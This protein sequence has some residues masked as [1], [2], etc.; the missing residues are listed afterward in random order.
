MKTNITPNKINIAVSAV[1]MGKL[2][3]FADAKITLLV[4]N[5]CVVFTACSS[6]QKLL[7]AA[8]NKT[9]CK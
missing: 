3:Y 9:V 6:G 1:K 5:S 8:L 7:S 2:L 4:D